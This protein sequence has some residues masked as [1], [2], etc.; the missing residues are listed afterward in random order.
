MVVAWLWAAGCGLGSTEAVE[1]P[2]E[3][4]VTRVA[5]SEVE[6]ALQQVVDGP[7]VDGLQVAWVTGGQIETVRLGSL[8]DVTGGLELG[9]VSEVVTGALLAEAQKRGSAPTGDGGMVEAV[10]ALEA[11]TGQ[12]YAT[13]LDSWVA[14]PQGLADTK[15]A[16]DGP[17]GHV[18]TGGGAPR[19]QWTVNGPVEAVTSSIDDLAVLVQG[20]I[21]AGAVSP[22]W[23]EDEGVR[24]QGGTSSGF[25]AYVGAVPADGVGVAIVADVAQPRLAPLGRALLQRARG[26]MVDIGLPRVAEQPASSM[27]DCVGQYNLRGTTVAVTGDGSGGLLAQMGDGTPAQMYPEGPDTYFV[28]VDAAHIE[29]LRKADGVYAL[30]LTRGERTVEAPRIRR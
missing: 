28:T 24:E 17:T 11:S 27:G 13:L 10:T 5:L 4:D 16:G 1:R 23:I 8:A 22:G 14:G 9:P 2:S 29:C 26:E 21:A 25:F 7:W 12:D 15:A 30:K 18:P 6:P 20:A 3:P 19:M